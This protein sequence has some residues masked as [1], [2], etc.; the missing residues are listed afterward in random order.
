MW[1]FN[2]VLELPQ[3]KVSQVEINLAT[4]QGT[5]LGFPSGHG[6]A[7]GLGMIAQRYHG[8]NYERTEVPVPIFSYSQLMTNSISESTEDRDGNRI[9]NNSDSPTRDIGNSGAIGFDDLFSA[10]QTITLFTLPIAKSSRLL[11]P[12]MEVITLDDPGGIETINQHGT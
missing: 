6:D 7:R 3:S 4:G 10:N 9:D 11:E 1:A 12:T 8:L 2:L 5:S